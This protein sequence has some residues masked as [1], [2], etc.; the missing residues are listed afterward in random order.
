MN[1]IAIEFDLK[2][3]SPEF[4][5]KLRDMVSDGSG[6]KPAYAAFIIN[7]MLIADFMRR[8]SIDL[9]VAEYSGSGDSGGIDTV[10]F[11]RGGQKV[12]PPQG[13]LSLVFVER[14]YREEGDIVKFTTL[15]GVARCAFERMTDDALDIRGHGG[16]ETNDGGYGEAIFKLEGS[17]DDDLVVQVA[18]N[19]Y[20]TNVVKDQYAI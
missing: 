13:R 7:K 20:V 1:I 11:Y 16:W 10:S 19:I 9:V 5:T 17:K 3:I 12:N 14:R 15:E 4:E 8:S 6:K 2:N 18:H